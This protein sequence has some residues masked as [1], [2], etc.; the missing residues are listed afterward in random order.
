M[1]SEKNLPTFVAGSLTT[2]RGFALILVLGVMMSVTLTIAVMEKLQAHSLHRSRLSLFQVQADYACYGAAVQASMNP[3]DTSTYYPYYGT[4]VQVLVLDP[5]VSLLKI[6]LD[7]GGEP[8]K[9]KLQM[10]CAQAATPTGDGEV[11][12]IWYYLI[13]ETNRPEIWTSWP[14]ILRQQPYK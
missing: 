3:P 11:G 14:G 1:N 7:R 9:G 13:N 12:A 6:M 5:P 4:N 8:A 10:V 2:R